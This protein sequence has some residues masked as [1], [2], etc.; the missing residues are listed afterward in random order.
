MAVTIYSVPGVLPTELT[1]YRVK[2]PMLSGTELVGGL[3]GQLAFTRFKPGE[4]SGVGISPTVSEL[5]VS[6]IY[7]MRLAETDVDTP[8]AMALYVTASGADPTAIFVS[9][10]PRTATLVV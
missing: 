4:T 10:L 3:S 8:G 6:G 5:T 7:E 2:F 1:S 9:V